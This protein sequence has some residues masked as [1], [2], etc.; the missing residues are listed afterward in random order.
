MDHDSPSWMTEDLQPYRA[1][2]RR[3]FAEKLAPRQEAWRAQGYV[4]RDFWLLAAEAGLLGAS[5]PEEYGGSGGSLAYDAVVFQELGRFADTNWGFMIQNFVSHYIVEYGAESQKVAWLPKLVRG[6]RVA[7]IAMTEPG[8]GSD[9]RSIRTRA[10][11]DGDSYVIDGAKTFITNG[12]TAD[13]ILLAVR[14]ADEASGL[15]LIVVETEGLEGFRRGRKLD[16]VG[17]PGQDTSELF[18]DRVRVPRFN[19]LGETPGQGFKQ[20]TGQ[21]AW[22]RM[23]IAIVGVE[24]AGRAVVETVDYV[25]QR[26]AFGKRLMDFQNTRFVLAE[27]A[28]KVEIHRAFVDQCMELQLAGKLHPATAAMAKLSVTQMQCEVVDACVQLHGGYGYMNEYLIGQM[29]VDSRIQKIYGGA[30]EIMK[31]IIARELDAPD[32]AQNRPDTAR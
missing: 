31:E 14:S 9:L 13:F 11:L 12:Q 4:E 5:I 23:A 3:L 1:L 20:L 19:L 21:L 17:Q 8:T 32:Y 6:E 2:V 26:Q 30:N 28:T 7:A 29:F 18:F 10:R 24:S 22:E 27:C 15:S 25:K 16:K